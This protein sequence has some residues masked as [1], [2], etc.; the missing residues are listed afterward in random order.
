MDFA[1]VVKFKDTVK[2]EDGKAEKKILINTDTFQLIAIAIGKKGELAAHPAPGNAVITALKGEATITYD[3]KD[4][5]LEEG[6]FFYMEKGV[7]HSLKADKK[8]E[9][10]VAISL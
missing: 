6:D 8:F 2:A 1:Q 10:T 4:Y 9:M 3:G 7:V 5:K